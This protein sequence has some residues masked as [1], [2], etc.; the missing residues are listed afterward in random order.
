MTD[1]TMTPDYVVR[2]S[3]I[4]GQLAAIARIL[5]ILIAG[6]GAL[7]KFLSAK[8]VAGAWVWMQ[9]TDGAGF[10]AAIVAA[11]TFGA[12]LYKTYVKHARTVALVKQ[13]D[14]TTA[15]LK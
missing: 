15:V 7:M 8:D 12:S 4:P 5:T 6:F 13:V 9:T 14:D 1:E 11:G 10:I 2:E 3:S